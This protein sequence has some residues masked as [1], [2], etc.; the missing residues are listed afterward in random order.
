M[1]VE[2][3]NREVTHRQVGVVP[4]GLQTSLA[5]AR[6]C[7]LQGR[8]ES[9]RHWRNRNKVWKGSGQTAGWP[10]PRKGI[11]HAR[12]SRGQARK[13]RCGDRGENVARSIAPGSS[14]GLETQ[15]L[16]RL[17]QRTLP[18]KCALTSTDQDDR[19]NPARQAT[20]GEGVG[21]RWVMAVSLQKVETLQR[22]GC[23]E[24]A[25]VGNWCPFVNR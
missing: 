14:Q 10:S 9:A 1:I 22:G 6:T 16:K 15:T 4:L 25:I 24:V 11:G 17:A 21:V 12:R 13:W 8:R 19:F 20:S 5:S 23:G 7:P 3:L 18:G 2:L